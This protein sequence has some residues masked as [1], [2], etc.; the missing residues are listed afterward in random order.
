VLVAAGRERLIFRIVAIDLLVSLVLGIILIRQFGLV[1]AAV[2]M[3][4]TK[5][6]D[7]ALHW[8]W[9]Y[10]FFPKPPIGR[11]LWKPVVASVCMGGYLLLMQHQRVLTAVASAGALYAATFL[12][13]SIVSIGGFRQF[14]AK[15]LYESVD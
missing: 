12:T 3:L 13:L 6:V 4:V 9:A 7:A 2:S 14:K 5:I 8:M 1:G 15:Y 10:R 11:L